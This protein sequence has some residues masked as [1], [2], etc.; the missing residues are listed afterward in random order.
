MIFFPSTSLYNAPG[1]TMCA[2]HS[3]AS[4]QPLGSDSTDHRQADSGAH[5]RR[6]RFPMHRPCAAPAP[7]LPTLRAGA[8]CAVYLAAALLSVQASPPTNGCLDSAHPTQVSRHKVSL[9]RLCLVLLVRPALG[10]VFLHVCPPVPSKPRAAAPFA[11]G[12]LHVAAL[13]GAQS[14]QAS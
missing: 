10:T 4:A 13:S 11:P 9:V 1:S 6:P 3:A 7:P 5:T 8:H 2:A 12:T 14:A